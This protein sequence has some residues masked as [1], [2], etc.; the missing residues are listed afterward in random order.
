[1]EFLEELEKSAAKDSHSA[2]GAQDQ[3]RSDFEKM[4]FDRI[5]A[6]SHEEIT[7]KD[8]LELDG[9]DEDCSMDGES[10][11]ACQASPLKMMDHPASDTNK[12]SILLAKME[13][14]NV[15]K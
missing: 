14:T 4:L 10:Q 11:G 6:K 13:Q 8:I 7:D 15:E 3:K 2:V 5:V 9:E 1:M 12:D